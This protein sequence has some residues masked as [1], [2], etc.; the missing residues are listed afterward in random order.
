MLQE[1]V[2]AECVD[3]IRAFAVDNLL[4]HQLAG[5]RGERN[6]VALVTGS[7]KEALQRLDRPQQRHAVRRIRTEAGEE[8]DDRNVLECREE[9]CCAVQHEFDGFKGVFALVISKFARAADNKTAVF[10]LLD[11]KRGAQTQDVLVLD[12]FRA[13]L[14]DIIA[15]ALDGGLHERA[16]RLRD[17]KLAFTGLNRQIQT[18]KLCHLA[19]PRAA[20]VDNHIGVILALVGLHALDRAVLDEETGDVGVCLNLRAQT[21]RGRKP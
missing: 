4:G 1:T 19:S 2:R 16:N 14:D 6:A 18:G 20:G 5:N 7:H 11:G 10:G 9:A 13:E 17:G 15:C 12:G 3:V 21:Q 8:T